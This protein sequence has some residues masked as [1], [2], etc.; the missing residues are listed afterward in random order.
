MPGTTR[1]W[2]E[3]TFYG[4]QQL[5]DRWHLGYQ[6][7]RFNWGT[8]PDQYTLSAFQR[9]ERAKPGHA[10]VMAEIPLVTSHAPW[11]PLPSRLID[12]KDV[13]DGS[14]FGPMAAAGDRP[15]AVW[16]DPNR[17]RTAYRKSIQYS[18]NALVSYVRTYGDK[19]LVL[20]FLGD[21]QPAPLVTGAGASRDVPITIVAR[22]P[23]VLN[24]ISGWGWQD[25]LKPGPQAPVWR[26]NTF[27]DRFLTAFGSTATPR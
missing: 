17:V 11:A 7:P 6:G 26:M 1:A 23:A 2:S 9:F 27:R 21:H 15:E 22:D 24:Q 25:G 3:G 5:Y 19:N 8:P 10:P 18:L 16:R 4:Y 13:G 20:V 12:W 14:V